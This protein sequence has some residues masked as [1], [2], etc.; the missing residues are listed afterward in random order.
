L[1]E[2]YKS[3]ILLFSRD[4]EPEKQQLSMKDFKEGAL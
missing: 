1:K 3:I 4:A 2:T